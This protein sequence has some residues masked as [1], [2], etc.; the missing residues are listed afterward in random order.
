MTVTN[1]SALVRE[2]E[3]VL[4]LTSFRQLSKYRSSSLSHRSSVL[5]CPRSDV[6]IMCV[7]IA[8]AA[9][10][11]A[12]NTKQ[13]TVEKPMQFDRAAWLVPYFTERETG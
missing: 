6:S 11:A 12:V 1:M 9:R 7:R 4:K 13:L 5:V 2:G 3:C 10:R 8:R